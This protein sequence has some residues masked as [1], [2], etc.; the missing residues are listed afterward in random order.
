MWVNLLEKA[1]AEYFGCYY[2]IEYGYLYEAFRDLTGAPS[3]EIRLE[4]ING[5]IKN[6]LW[7]NI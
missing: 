5:S 7:N 3:F 4:N 1:Y 6:S 2:N